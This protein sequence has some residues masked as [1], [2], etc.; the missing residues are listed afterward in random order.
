MKKFFIFSLITISTFIFY[1]PINAQNN[2]NQENNQLKIQIQ[3]NNQNQSNSQ[4]S[5]EEREQEKNQLQ[6]ENTNQNQEKEQS[7]NVNRE[8]Q[9]QSQVENATQENQLK[10]QKSNDANTNQPPSIKEQTKIIGERLSNLIGDE[11]I[12]NEITN[13]IEN[14]FNKN[15]NIQNDA[16]EQLKTLQSKQGIIRKL[17]GTDQRIVENLEK[18]IKINEEKLNQLEKLKLNINDEQAR[19]EIEKIIENT[20]QENQKLADQ[21]RN[22]KNIRGAL[23]WFVDIGKKAIDLIKNLISN[24][25]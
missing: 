12:D 24:Q 14:F 17:F 10:N 15:E 5:S 18:Q 25:Q 3:E 1:F 21:I 20:N 22:E 23:S 16:Q 4:N 9:N 8:E 11:K 7:N 2:Q 19:Q 6:T 13:Q